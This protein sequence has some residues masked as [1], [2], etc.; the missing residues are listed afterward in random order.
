ML[1][2]MPGVSYETFLAEAPSLP[3]V[4]AVVADDAAR[5][6]L[7]LPAQ[8]TGLLAV[9]AAPH[10]LRD[11]DV[12]VAF[13]SGRTGAS[14]LRQGLAA[15]LRDVLALDV[16]RTSPGAAGELSTY[17]VPDSVESISHILLPNFILFI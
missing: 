17:L 1:A 16:E 12:R 7:G 9:T 15:L 10:G 5:A 11:R 13:Q 2:A 4:V 6:A 14:P 8:H 3:G